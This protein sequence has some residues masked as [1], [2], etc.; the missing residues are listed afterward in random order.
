ML[1]SRDRKNKSH[2][3][4]GKAINSKLFFSKTQSLLD[5]ES[6]KFPPPKMLHNISHKAI[7]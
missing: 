6:V 7:N 3:F 4:H 1:E 2:I 5:T